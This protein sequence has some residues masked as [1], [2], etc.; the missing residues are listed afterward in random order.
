[1]PQSH[2]TDQHMACQEELKTDNSDMTFLWLVGWGF[3]G[4]IGITWTNLVKV[5]YVIHSTYQK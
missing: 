4:P 3:F 5:Y 2:T 1:M